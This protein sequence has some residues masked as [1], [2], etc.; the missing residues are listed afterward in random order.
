MSTSWDDRY[1]D[2]LRGALRLLPAADPLRPDLD[3]AGAGLDSLATVELLVSL[4]DAYDL[5]IP[6]TLLVPETFA[7]PN[8]LWKAVSSLR[9]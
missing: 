5:V 6:D 7:T 2:L 1:E 8:S 9:G 3:M 4:E